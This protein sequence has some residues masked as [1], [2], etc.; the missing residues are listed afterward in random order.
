VRRLIVFLLVAVA[1]VV[2]PGCMQDIPP[3]QVRTTVPEPD[4][5]TPTPEPITTPPVVVEEP[6]KENE[7]MAEKEK[8]QTEQ[9]APEVVIP[10]PAKLCPLPVYTAYLVTDGGTVFGIPS[11]L[12][13]EGHK[14]RLTITDTDGNTLQGKIGF[15]TVRGILYVVREWVDQI[16]TEHTDYYAQDLS[17]AVPTISLVDSAPK[18]PDVERV[19]FDSPEWLIKSVV[20]SGVEYSYLYNRHAS[21][22]GGAG[23][24]EWVCR[25]NKITGFVVLENGILIMSED[26]AQFCPANRKG[27]NMVGECGRLWK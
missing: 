6:E 25:K 16:G 7:E 4:E 1:V 20:L 22:W 12:M 19:T 26:G 17:T 11:G 8:E 9:T 18:M 2:V 14:E 23:D 24:G 15:Y 27:L 21:V 3:E 13:G 5:S 10:E